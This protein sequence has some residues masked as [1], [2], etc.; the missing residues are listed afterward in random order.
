MTA[1][2]VPMHV[3]GKRLPRVD[4]GE[5]V[6]GRA[7]YPADLTRPGMVVGRIKRSPHAHARI[8]SIDTS[9]ARALKG[10]L[11]VVTASDFPVIEPGTMIP[12]GETGADVWVSALTVIASDRV[13]WRGHPIAAVAAVDAYVAAAALELIDVE[14]EVLPAMMDIE[15]ASAPDALLIHPTMKPI[16]LIERALVN[17]SKKGDIV[18]DLFGG[19]G[20]TLIAAERMDRKARLLELDP[21]Y[22]DVICQRF[23]NFSGKPAT[24]EATGQTFL[25]VS[26]ARSSVAA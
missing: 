8:L 12:F 15:A 21:R 16:E 6:T 23:M 18:L 20:S 26:A 3:V 11:A 19:S 4:A 13:L 5:R 2:E 22:C 7:T 9:K 14:Y 1:S 24:L 25:E 17:S 10:V